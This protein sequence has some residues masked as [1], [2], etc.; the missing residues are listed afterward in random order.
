LNLAL[1]QLSVEDS[2]RYSVAVENSAFT[3]SRE[4]TIIVKTPRIVPKGMKRHSIQ[5]IT[6]T[7]QYKSGKTKHRQASDYVMRKREQPQM[8]TLASALRSLI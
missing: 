2:G 3:D 4:S 6:P 7:A 1:T 8:I 5:A